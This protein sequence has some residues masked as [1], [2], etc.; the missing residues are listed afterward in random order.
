[1]TTIAVTGASGFIGRH[2]VAALTN[3]GLTVRGFTRASTEPDFRRL[4]Y[5]DSD[6]AARALDGIEVVIHVAGL[7][8]ISSK[9]LADPL[10]AFRTANTEVAANIAKASARTGVRRL[11]LLSSAGVLGRESPPGGFSD[12]SPALPYD[13]YT[14][15]KFEAEQR[16]L[17]AASGKISVVILRP[18]MVYGPG[19]PGSY[20]RLCAWIDRGLPL[21]LGSIVARRSLVGIRNLCSLLLTVI[22]STKQESSTLL[23]SDSEPLTVAELAKRIAVARNRQAML[24]PVP[25]RLLKWT[26]RGVG[27]QDEYR[28][29]ALPFELRP[30]RAR[31][32]F[33]WQPPHSTAEELCWALARQRTV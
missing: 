7:A 25:S 23:V 26:L 2:V 18:P 11:V 4:D 28:R 21:P 10:A 15:S 5:L 31:E 8:H 13:A 32:I 33:G 30:S 9:S 22:A 14:L 29:L 17:E 24:L 19:A 16:V 6:A 20:R 1:M 27:L 3:A 12:S